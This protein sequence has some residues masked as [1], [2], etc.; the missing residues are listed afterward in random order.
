MLEN[1][2]PCSGNLAG[3]NFSEFGDLLQIYQSFICQLLAISEKARGWLK[4]AKVFFAKYNLACYSPKFS[5][6]KN[7]PL[8]GI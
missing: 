2:L 3:E 6:T 7:F 8:Y 4:F 1:L 5:P